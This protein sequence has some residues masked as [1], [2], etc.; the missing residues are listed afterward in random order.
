MAALIVGGRGYNGDREE[1]S[2]I[3]TML[4]DTKMAGVKMPLPY[5][6]IWRLWDY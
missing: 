4:A 1:I 5:N 6:D 2:A 3:V